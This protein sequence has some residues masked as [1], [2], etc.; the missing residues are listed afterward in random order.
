MC[1]DNISEL[2]VDCGESGATVL[3]QVRD[4]DGE[5]SPDSRGINSA[6]SSE[7]TK[8]VVRKKVKQVTASRKKS[9]KGKDLTK[10]K[11]KFWGSK[12]KKRLLPQGAREERAG[13]IPES[14]HARGGCVCTG[15]RKTEDNVVESVGAS[16]SVLESLP[17]SGRTSPQTSVSHIA[18]GA[19]PSPS[20]LSAE[21][22]QIVPPPQR[23]QAAAAPSFG[24]A[25]PTSFQLGDIDIDQVRRAQRLR[26]IE[27]G[28]EINRGGGHSAAYPHFQYPSASRNSLSASSSSNSDSLW[29]LTCSFQS[30]C[31][32]NVPRCQ[33]PPPPPPIVHGGESQAL[34]TFGHGRGAGPQ[35]A[36]TESS[37]LLSPPPPGPCIPRIEYTQ[38]D[39]IH[40]LVPDLARIANCSFYWGVMDRYEAERLLENRPEGTF[41][42]RDSAQDDFLFSVSFRR[43]QRSL[44]ARI[45]QWNHKFSFDTH[46]PGVYAATTVSGLIEHYKDPNCCMFFEPMLTIPLARNFPFSL[47]HL[48]RT[49]ICSKTTYDGLSFLP[50]PKSLCQYLK[51]Y[52]YKQKVRVRHM[53]VPV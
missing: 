2:D 50:L 41:L 40:C 30:H 33:P 25:I 1:A 45:D 34:T 27:L 15:F 13:P 21:L 38:V 17:S 10:K 36:M 51:Y 19:G 18:M 6:G 35:D 43:Y 44:H 20:S 52:H 3:Q 5:N 49:V 16:A 9:D 42:L 23:N 8:P 29:S 7:T 39:Y 46:D 31:S 32:T 22:R 53:Q 28:I 14:S 47:Q 12:L 4:A 48:C 11:S 26:D 37:S 24:I